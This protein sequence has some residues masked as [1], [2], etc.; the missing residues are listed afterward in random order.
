[1]S[2]IESEGLQLGE[3]VTLSSALPQVEELSY[4]VQRDG[5]WFF[6]WSRVEGAESYEIQTAPDAAQSNAWAVAGKVTN[7]EW[8]CVALSAPEIWICVRAIGVTG[9][10]PWCHPLLIKNRGASSRMA[11]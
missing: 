4:A 3:S 9:A 2:K 7:P 8:S 11:A 6:T 1:M 5:T 10:G